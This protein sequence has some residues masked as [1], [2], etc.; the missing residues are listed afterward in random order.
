MKQLYSARQGSFTEALVE[1]C[2][3]EAE[4]QKDDVCEFAMA[5]THC[6]LTKIKFSFKL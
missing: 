6:Y 3:T 2:H 1:K 5:G 4:K